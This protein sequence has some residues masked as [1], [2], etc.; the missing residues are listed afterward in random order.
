[1]PRV[2]VSGFEEEV[3][4]VPIHIVN[5]LR[6]ENEEYRNVALGRSVVHHNDQALLER[7]WDTPESPVNEQRCIVLLEETDRNRMS[8]PDNPLYRISLLVRTH[9]RE[10][11]KR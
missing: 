1:M 8:P 6:V 4:G 11:E 2:E 10:L 7:M 3:H 5:L 9:E